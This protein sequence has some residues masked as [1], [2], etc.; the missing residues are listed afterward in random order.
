MKVCLEI[1]QGVFGEVGQSSQWTWTLSHYNWC[2]ADPINYLSSSSTAVIE[3]EIHVYKVSNKIFD[4]MVDSVMVH[5]SVYS[6][7]QFLALL[8]K[9]RVWYCGRGTKGRTKANLGL[10]WSRTTLS[11][12]AGREIADHLASSRAHLPRAIIG[13]GWRQLAAP[14][15]QLRLRGEPA[16]TKEMRLNRAQSTDGLVV[17]NILLLT[18]FCLKIL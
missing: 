15:I 3:M 12:W 10:P 4:R 8:I 17:I 9:E 11:H 1:P 2:Q 13:Q 5:N 7:G 16:G 14:M 6:L 18:L